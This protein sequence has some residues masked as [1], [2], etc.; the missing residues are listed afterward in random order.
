MFRDGLESSGVLGRGGIYVL[1]LA[2]RGIVNKV[3]VRVC[4]AELYCLILAGL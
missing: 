1:V 2:G 4:K 3:V